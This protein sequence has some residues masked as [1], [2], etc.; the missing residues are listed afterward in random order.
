[1]QK[2][3]QKAQKALSRYV[4]SQF[5]EEMREDAG[6]VGLY[7]YHVLLE[8]FL[9]ARPGLH[10]VRRPAID[11]AHESLPV[12]G[13]YA[14]LVSASPEP[15]ALQYVYDVLFEPTDDDVILSENETTLCW[16]VLHTAVLCL[17]EA[18]AR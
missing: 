12:S 10:P 4:Y 11:R 15:H 3:H 9:A 17:H 2:R 6:G 18:R 5:L 16:R 14:D 13:T 8:A 1:M 7:A